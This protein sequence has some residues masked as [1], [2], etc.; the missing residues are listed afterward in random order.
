MLKIWLLLSVLTLCDSVP[1]PFNNTNAEL[2]KIDYCKLHCKEKEYG[3]H[4][5]CFCKRRSDRREYLHNMTG[6]RHYMQKKHNYLRNL[7]A[8]GNEKRQNMKSATNMMLLNYDLQLEYS[9]RCFARFR[10]K[11]EHDYCKPRVGGTFVGQNL[12]GNTL[13]PF[14]DKYTIEEMHIVSW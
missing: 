3:L 13:Y 2:K 12:A 14:D 11:G 8:S 10:F 1:A 7:V 6:F 4:S 9:A 5:A